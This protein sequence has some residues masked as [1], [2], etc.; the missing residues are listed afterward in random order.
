MRN[1]KDDGILIQNNVTVN[2]STYQSINKM[3][4]LGRTCN[5]KNQAK[6]FPWNGNKIVKSTIF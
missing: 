4:S 1:S 5:G 3:R 2:V 6:P